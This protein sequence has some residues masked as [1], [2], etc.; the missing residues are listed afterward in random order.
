[1]LKSIAT[2]QKI[3]SRGLSELHASASGQLNEREIRQLKKRVAPNRPLVLVDLRGSFH[4]YINGQPIRWVR[5]NQKVTI[6][7]VITVEKEV[8]AAIFSQKK[9]GIRNRTKTHDHVVAV[10]SA[11]TES[12]LAFKYGLEYARFPVESGS[13]PADNVIDA[14]VKFISKLDPETHLHLHC[15]EGSGRATTVF[16]MLD[17]LRNANKATFQDIG[18]RHEILGGAALLEKSKYGTHQKFLK[19]FYAY[20]RARLNGLKV[21][22]LTYKK[23]KR[24]RLANFESNKPK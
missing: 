21:S 3:S 18:K 15:L 11:E 20:A 4:G 9:L 17:M 22:W 6:N 16:I 7:T 10:K 5:K 13:I 8:I 24:A 12:D 1:M 19:E 14:F 23:R 2:S